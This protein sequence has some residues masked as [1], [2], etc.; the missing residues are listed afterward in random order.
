MKISFLGGTGTVT[1]SKFLISSDEDLILVDCG[2]FQGLKQLRLLNWDKMLFDPAKLKAV[3]LTHAHLDHCGYI[4]LLV[5]NGFN[6]PIFGTAPTLELAKI[7][8][9]DAAKIQMEDAEYANKKGFSKHHPALPL[10]DI[11]D[12]EKS[13]LNF[14]S[15]EL[16]KAFSIGQFQIELSSGGHILGASSVLIVDAKK[17]IFFSGDL[18]RTEDPLMPIPSIPKGAEYVVMESTYGDR[19]H[20]PETSGDILKKLINQ[21]YQKNG[22]LLIPAFAV[23]RSQNL[24]YEIVCL[25]QSGQIPSSIPIYYNS[26]M[27][28]EVWHLYQ[29]YSQFQKIELN[30][31]EA[32]TQ[33]V[34]F[35]KNAEESKR[36]NE[37]KGPMIIIAASG[38]LTG[39]R[40]LH[41]LKAFAGDSKNIILLAGFQVIGTR[42]WLLASGQKRIKLHGIYLDIQA[43]VINSEAFSAHADQQELLNW[44][45]C[46]PHRPQVI[47]LVHGE[48]NSSDE[49]RRKIQDT[50]KLNVVIPKLH[51]TI[52]LDQIN[53]ENPQMSLKPLQI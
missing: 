42:G 23:G 52:N 33:E 39:G 31:F 32:V 28:E 51:D 16:N 30:K 4:P 1:G 17:R 35:I 14:Q 47:F 48:P 5:K 21:I 50:L 45:S 18:G 37:K 22:V 6:G 34:H 46:S 2:L 27:G 10:Y 19:L 20:S 53:L 13:F 3:I 29:K 49:L 38:M 26:P 25:K 11:A 12:A 43:Q 36:L 24:L 7:I 41:H 8:L 9:L 40:V 15:K 44:L